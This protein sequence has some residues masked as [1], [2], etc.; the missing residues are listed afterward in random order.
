MCV[1][2]LKLRSMINQEKQYEVIHEEMW[3]DCILLRFVNA[4]SG[5]DV[6]LFDDTKKVQYD[7]FASKSEN[8]PFRGVSMYG[9]VEMTICGGRPV[10]QKP[11]VRIRRHQQ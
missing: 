7:T 6:I 2:E 1:N 8:S 10:Y 11:T 5:I 4:L 3:S 9:S